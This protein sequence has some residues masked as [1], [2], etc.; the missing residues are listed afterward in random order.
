MLIDYGTT[1]DLTSLCGFND[2]IPDR[3]SFSKFIKKAGSGTMK[4]VFG[5]SMYLGM[6]RR[7]V[8]KV[9]MHVALCYSAIL[10]TA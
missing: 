1:F 2:N 6:G 3:M 8:A 10:A 9:C 7:G 4:E 5:L